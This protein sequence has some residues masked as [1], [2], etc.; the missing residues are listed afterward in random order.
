MSPLPFCNLGAPPGPAPGASHPPPEFGG[1]RAIGVPPELRRRATQARQEANEV[2]DRIRL[3]LHTAQ[4]KL[5]YS[6][7]KLQS[8]VDARRVGVSRE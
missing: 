1:I 2:A 5:L 4:L 8:A 7:W 3:A 6:K